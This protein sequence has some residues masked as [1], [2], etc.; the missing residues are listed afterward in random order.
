V[1]RPPRS[2]EHAA[3]AD[4]A[5]V[6]SPHDTKR[7]VTRRRVIF[8]IVVLALIAGAGFVRSCLL[9]YARHHQINDAWITAGAE[10]RPYLVGPLLLNRTLTRLGLRPWRTVGEITLD[11]RPIS[12]DLLATLADLDELH[13]LTLRHTGLRD[14][15]LKYLHDLPAPPQLTLIEPDLSDA[16][17]ASL[18]D[19]LPNVEIITD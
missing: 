19:R 3:T 10:T 1:I 7:F 15:Q 16:A 18:R 5:Y 11:H 4:V 8:A 6:N 12:D 2:P 17:L 9:H 14:E 13:T